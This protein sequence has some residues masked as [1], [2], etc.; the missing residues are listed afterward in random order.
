[1]PA[2]VT[3]S[4]SGAKFPLVPACAGANVAATGRRI[5]FLLLCMA[6]PLFAVLSPRPSSVG[7]TNGIVTITWTNLSLNHPWL[8]LT[9]TNAGQPQFWQPPLYAE[10]DG[11]LRHSEPATNTMKMFWLWPAA[12]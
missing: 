8:I 9:R 6:T 1:M 12:P 2:F 10:P 5:L 4:P 3:S 7:V 11:T